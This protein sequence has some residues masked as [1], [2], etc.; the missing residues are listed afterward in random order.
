MYCLMRSRQICCTYFPITSS[1]ANWQSSNL[2]LMWKGSSKVVS[3]SVGNR[4]TLFEACC[5]H[6]NLFGCTLYDPLPSHKAPSKWHYDRR[7]SIKKLGQLPNYFC[8][9][10]EKELPITFCLKNV[11]DFLLIDWNVK[12]DDCNIFCSLIWQHCFSFLYDTF[13]L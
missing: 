1:Q 6:F 7:R 13:F 5:L 8:G 3:L 11:R 4:R 2:N 9:E 12:N 10:N